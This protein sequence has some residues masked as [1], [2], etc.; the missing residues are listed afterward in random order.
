M[1]ITAF[2]SRSPGLFKPGAQP[3]WDMVLIPASSLQLIWSSELQL[4]LLNRG[5]WGP[6]LLG[7]GSLYRILSPTDWNF[8]SPG[9]YNNLT[10]TL[11]PARV[12][13]SHSIRPLDSQG[14]ILIFLDRMHLLFTLVHFLFWQPGR[15]GVNIQHMFKNKLHFNTFYER[16]L[17]R[18]WTFQPNLV[19]THTHTHIYIYI[20]TILP[21]HLIKMILI[22]LLKGN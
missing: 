19:H 10:T 9:L 11:L 17:V 13:I 4:Q 18:V 22:W 15:V 3:F 5:S 14:Y 1:A 12:T 20:Y 6:P 7:A 2:L 21:S 8:L 16:I